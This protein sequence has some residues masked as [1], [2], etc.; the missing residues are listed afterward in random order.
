M[1]KL[2]NMSGGVWRIVAVAVISS[3]LA[4]NA[5]ILT[6]VKT[7]VHSIDTKLFTHLINADIHIPREQV[8]SKAEF[9]L[10]KSFSDQEIE[11][12]LGRI[13]EM[14]DDLISKIDSISVSRR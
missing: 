9:Q 1:E 10:Y 7:E 14:K 4:S 11:R 8:V 12:I 6:G 5:L 3:L 13:S 2:N